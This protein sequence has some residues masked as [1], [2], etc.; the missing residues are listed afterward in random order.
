MS[1]PALQ[2][3]IGRAIVDKEFCVQL[4]N[5][6]RAAAVAEFRLTDAERDAVLGIR[7]GTLEEFA[8]KLDQW[9]EAPNALPGRCTR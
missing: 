6:R 4:L 5:G 7:A 1:H 3:L 2:Q 9:I 8:A